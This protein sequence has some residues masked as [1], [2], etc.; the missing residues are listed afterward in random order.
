VAKEFIFV[1]FIAILIVLKL[2]ESRVPGLVFRAAVLITVLVPPLATLYAIWLLWQRWVGWGELALFVGL[3]LA[4]GLGTTLGYHRLL[5]HRSFETRPFVK[6]LFLILGSMALQGRCIDWAAIH[7]KHHAMSDQEGDPH[8]PVEGLFHAHLGWIFGDDQPER[9]KY[10][11]RLLADP[12]VV[13]VD[14]TAL[15]WV[16]LGLVIPY[17]VAGW[18]GLLW[19]GLVRIAF[20]NHVTWSVNSICHTFGKQPFNTGDHS[21]NNIWVA[22]LAMGEGWHNNHHAFPSMA[23]HGMG[24]R[25]FDLTA[26]VIRLLVRLRLA[27]NVKLPASQFVERRKRGEVVV[28]A[29]GD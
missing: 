19:G 3:F 18:H 16:V 29:P 10:C 23:Y 28:P 12:L 13:F 20:G 25:Q 1:G 2:F 9:E 8:S 17:A 4:T 11:K 14:R 24:W 22:I 26:M 15:V 6:L 21:R 5:T 7:L 27:W